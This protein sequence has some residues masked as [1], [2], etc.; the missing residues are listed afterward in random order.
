MISNVLV[1]LCVSYRK[2]ECQCARARARKRKIQGK[3]IEW[4]RPRSGAHEHTNSHEAIWTLEIDREPHICTKEPYIRSKE[5]YIHSNES[6]IYSK[7]TYVH[8]KLRSPV[9]TQKSPIVSCERKGFSWKVSC[10]ENLFDW[11]CVCACVSV[12]V[13]VLWVCLFVCV[14]L[15]VCTMY[16]RACVRE[17]ETHRENGS[18]CASERQGVCGFV[19]ETQTHVCQKHSKDARC[20]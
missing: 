5:P 3:K 16:V 19:C 14:C 4:G 6:S 1:Y 11:C 7:E 20:K 12:C 18:K 13:C 9:Y 2:C 10:C 17:R 15:C 8:S